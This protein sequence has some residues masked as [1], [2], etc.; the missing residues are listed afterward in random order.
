MLKAIIIDS[1]AISRDLLNAILLNEKYEIVGHSGSG[2]Q[3]LALAI[4]HKPHIICVDMEIV[5]SGEFLLRLREALPKALI[6]MMSNELK[7]D[8][9]KD[10]IA[11]GV[12][13]VIIKPFNT[14]KVTATIKNA[15]LAYVKRQQAALAQGQAVV[16]AQV[17]P[18]S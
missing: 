3:G 5:Y 1:S 16:A 8:I 7:A 10:A 18:A 13:G 11:R 4:K 15:V 17:P 6:F 2:N 12:H 14:V 9:L